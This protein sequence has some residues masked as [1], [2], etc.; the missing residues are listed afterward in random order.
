M[1]VYARR[2]FGEGSG[3]RLYSTNTVNT[4]HTTSVLDC[5]VVMLLA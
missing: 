5:T 4:A 1:Y 3:Y 2:R